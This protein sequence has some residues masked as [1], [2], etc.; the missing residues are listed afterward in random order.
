[1]LSRQI[2]RAGVV[3]ASGGNHGAAVAYASMKL[4]I[5]AKIFVPTISSPAKVQRIRDYH[6][7]LVV[8]GNR[9]A[10]ALA[11]S[12][13]WAEQSGA[14][15]IH[16]FDQRETLLGQGTIGLETEEQRPDIDTLLVSVGGGGLW[17]RSGFSRTPPHRHPRVP[18]RQAACGPRSVGSRR[19]DQPCPT[20]SLGDLEGSRRAWRCCRLR[21]TCFGSL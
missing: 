10:D 6:A 18:H 2:P 19:S 7:E 21:S 3:A 8:T 13:V 14:L 12:E 20:G 15:S 1:M 9:Y 17:D 5:T 11:A 4:G 16:A